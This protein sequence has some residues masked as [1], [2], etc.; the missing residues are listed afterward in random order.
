M[1]TAQLSKRLQRALGVRQDRRRRRAKRAHGQDIA[2]RGRDHVDVTT[3][4]WHGGGGA[5]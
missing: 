5:T 4:H 1:R 3:R 2:A